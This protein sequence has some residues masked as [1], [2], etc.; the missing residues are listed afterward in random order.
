MEDIGSLVIKLALDGEKFDSGIK[1]VNQQLKVVDSS[2]S[3]TSKI[4]IGITKSIS[5]MA[6]NTVTM[7]ETV[8][9]L[10]CLKV[11]SKN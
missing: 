4:V 1:R 10:K 3:T 2:F 5:R 8:R 7:L 9:E 6:R 11:T